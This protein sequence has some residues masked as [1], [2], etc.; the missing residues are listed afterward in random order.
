[1]RAVQACRKAGATQ[2]DA[3]ATHGVLLPEARQLLGP[4]GPDRLVVTDSILPTRLV[5]EP[6]S[7]RLVV[8]EASALFGE[9]IRRIGRGESVVALREMQPRKP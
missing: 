2:V 6:R 7:G 1:M 3:F 8:L 5:D 4:D 9:A